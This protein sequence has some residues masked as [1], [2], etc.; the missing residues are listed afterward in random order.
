VTRGPVTQANSWY[1]ECRH[2]SL[3]A[4]TTRL[5]CQKALIIWVHR[6]PRGLHHLGGHVPFKVTLALA[7]GMSGGITEMV[8][9]KNKSGM[10]SS[11]TRDHPSGAI[12][13]LMA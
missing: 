6:P 12:T 11:L 2:H 1:K 10:A 4:M 3:K 9:L 7:W 8:T 13:I 5:I